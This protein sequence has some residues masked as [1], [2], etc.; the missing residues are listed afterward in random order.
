M[1][2]GLSVALPLSMD[3]VDGAYALNKS[4]RR[5]A[6]QNLKMILLTSPGERVMQPDFGVGIRNY[7]FEQNARGL[8]AG[9]KQRIQNQVTKY[10]PYMIITDLKVFSPT[11][12]EYGPNVTDNTR[13]NVLISY[14]VPTLSISSTFAIAVEA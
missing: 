13:L 10:L 14:A 11:M 7:L 5:M 1:A 6:E 9:L 4:M 3:T 8:T 2:E 12:V